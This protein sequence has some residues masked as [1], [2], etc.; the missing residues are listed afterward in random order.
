MSIAQLVHPGR[1]NYACGGVGI[2]M[3]GRPIDQF[4]SNAHRIGIQEEAI[5]RIFTT[6]S[7]N[8]GRLTK[9]GEDWYSLFNTLGQCHH[10]YIHRFH[11]IDT[12]VEFYSAIT[13]LETSPAQLLKQGEQIWNLHRLLNT[14][15]GF[16]RKDDEPPQAWVEP[17][18]IGFVELSLMDYYRAKT[19]SRD[20]VQEMLD[21]YYDERGWDKKSGVPTSETLSR[22]G[23]DG[24]SV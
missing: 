10:L 3:Q 18:K 4:V 15:L 16:S 19:I 7:F 9:Y 21:E 11:S 22:L 1:P 5:K 12:S 20:D 23:L 8:L 14:R 6:S 24:L 2:Y 17:L 13:G